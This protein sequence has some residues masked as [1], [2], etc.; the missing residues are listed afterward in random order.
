MRSRAI[1][2]ASALC[3]LLLILL[4]FFGTRTLVLASYTATTATQVNHFSPVTS[5]RS[6][7]LDGPYHT[8]GNRI[9]GAD[10]KPYL[11]HGIGRSGL[12]FTCF[13]DGHYSAQE[14]SYMGTG[15]NTSTAT[16]WQANTV[17]LPLSEYFWLKGDPTK[18]C[19]AAQY[20]QLVKNSV[21]ALTKSQINV[22]L[23]LHHSDA[24]GQVTGQGQTLAMP[25][26]DSVTFWKQVA[27]T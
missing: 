4:A 25:D 8:Q 7:G 21:A 24:G 16:Y 11:F 17:R 26:A 14:L 18:Y 12:E 3:T 6:K 19:P 10:K 27:A 23:D 2:Y 20:Q 9:I 15:K 5:F 22:I 1:L 13:G